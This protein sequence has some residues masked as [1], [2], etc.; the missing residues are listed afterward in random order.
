VE[1]IKRNNNNVL[2]VFLDLDGLK[3]INDNFGHAVGDIAIKAMGDILVKAFRQTDIIARIGGDEFTVLAIS[4]DITEYNSIIARA[5]CMVNEYNIISGQNFRLSFS[6][7][8][9][10]SVSGKYF[11]L[12]ELM[13]EA[14]S[15]LYSAK[16]EK[17]KN[18]EF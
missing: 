17:K 6:S 13:E 18:R 10:P 12:E 15:K 1:L 8:A 9:A 7:G 5:E 16:R 2:L 4:C 3:H 14:D 11:S